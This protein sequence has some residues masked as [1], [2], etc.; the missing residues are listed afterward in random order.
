MTDPDAAV[1]VIIPVHNGEQFLR[2]AIEST[3]AQDRQPVEVVV[4]DDGSTDGSAEIA[5]SIPGVRYLYQEH[6]GIAAARNHGVRV[7]TEDL[8]AFLDADD[9]WPPHKLGLQV[10]HLQVSE[11]LDG[12]LGL[13][14]SF[15]HGDVAG[16][17]RVNTEER[18]RGYLAGALLIRREAFFRAGFFPEGRKAGE[19]I[20]WYGRAV[21]AGLTFALVDEVVLLRRVHGRNLTLTAGAEGRGDYV[22][23]MRGV[24]ERRGRLKA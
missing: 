1:S 20:D 19:F 16:R 2:E 22:R 8:V 4:V 13:V 24:L 17:Y 6:A 9:L 11:A 12:V 10:A 14:T 3:L 15:N 23:I 5:R 21:D 18:A 7:S